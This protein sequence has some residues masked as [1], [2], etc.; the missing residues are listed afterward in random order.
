MAMVESRVIAPVV[1]GRIDLN[2]AN[3]RVRAATRAALN[4]Q[5]PPRDV[6]ISGE[7]LLK[8]RLGDKNRINTVNAP[9]SK[10]RVE[11]K[12]AIEQLNKADRALISDIYFHA[13]E[14]GAD[15]KYVDELARNLARYREQQ[16]N[17]DKA[18]KEP[19]GY[20]TD[21]ERL[22]LKRIRDSDALS[23]T[24]LDQ[25]FVR[26]MT[27]PDNPRVHSNL[28][29]MEQVMEKFSDKGEQAPALSGKFAQYSR[30]PTDD[31]PEAR[32]QTAMPG[33]FGLLT[34]ALS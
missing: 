16:G 1:S 7:G 4:N 3:E 29:F 30:L 32:K 27:D 10:T 24:R 20:F 12:P 17:P 8:Q 33:L 9:D 2:K 18:A 11:A 23:S 31:R 19:R 34:K 28:E 26:Y 25:G 15:L 21:G 22:T 14:Q 13:R 6:S 5:K